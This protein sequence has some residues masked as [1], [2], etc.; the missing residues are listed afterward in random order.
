MEINRLIER[1]LKGECSPEEIS[2][3]NDFFKGKQI[4][5]LDKE[6]LETWN[7]KDEEVSLKLKEDIVWN[8]LKG[9]IVEKEDT[10]FLKTSVKYRLLMLLKYAAILI[11]VI[12]TVFYVYN[13]TK[14]K[15]NSRKEEFVKIRL[16]DGS[17]KS[18]KIKNNIDTLR[19]S[20]DKIATLKGNKLI[21]FTK[22]KI[23]K[24]KELAYNELSVPYG[25]KF[26]LVLSDGS[27]IYLNSGSSLKYP[28]EFMKGQKR[29][30][31][32]EGE[33]Y[34]KISKNKEEAFIV[35]TNKVS[36]QVYG[37]E[38]NI[39]SYENE[40]KV[41]VVLVEG[42]VGVYN[43][44]N[45]NKERK[46]KPDQI[47]SYSKIDHKMKVDFVDIDSHIAWIDNV[48]LFKNEKFSVILKK[49]ERHYGVEFIDNTKNFTNVRFTGRF[50]VESIEEVLNT[51]NKVLNF[52]YTKNNNQIIINP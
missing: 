40:E 29:E 12:S 11:G 15:E 2:I 36:T 39:T 37:T 21:Y 28:E 34:F 6:F 50:E 38:F 16:S 20:K 44:S 41:N 3:L 27:Q 24:S 42:S 46:L 9:K 8:K 52:K 49:L 18:F 33:G 43:K 51:I 30:V 13:S 5:E 25:K 4:K 7:S 47:A 1:F 17:I 48:L 19:G 32:L 23:N 31:Y 45:N 35:N 22:D 14:L 10:K 26:Q